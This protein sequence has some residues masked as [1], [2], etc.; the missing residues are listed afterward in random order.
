MQN[1]IAD[2]SAPLRSLVAAAP[3]LALCV[4]HQARPPARASR[5]A[6]RVG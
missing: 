4:A 6:T 3:K 2:V 5:P 1:D